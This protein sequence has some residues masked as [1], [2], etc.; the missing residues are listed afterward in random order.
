MEWGFLPQ[1]LGCVLWLRLRIQPVPRL[2]R[3]HPGQPATL[4]SSG[5]HVGQ[6]TLFFF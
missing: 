6:R 5:L 1:Y 3:Q 4:R 2:P